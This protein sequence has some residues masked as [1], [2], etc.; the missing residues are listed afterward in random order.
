MV[1]KDMIGLTDDLC[2]PVLRASLVSIKERI[3]V[4]RSR[5]LTGRLKPLNDD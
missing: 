2:W 4:Q 1:P 5:R 3:I